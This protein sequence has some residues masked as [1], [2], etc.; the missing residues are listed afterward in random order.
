MKEYKFLKQKMSWSKSQDN[1]EDQ[2]NAEA[3]Q[4]WRVVNVY[5]TQE[6]RVYAMLERDKNR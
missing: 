2:I 1:F 5:S 6:S 4:G 3:K